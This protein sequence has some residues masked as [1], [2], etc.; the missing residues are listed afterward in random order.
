MT[1]KE[2]VQEFYNLFFINDNKCFIGSKEQARLM[3]QLKFN[4]Y[5]PMKLVNKAFN[6]FISSGLIFKRKNKQK[7]G[8]NIGE[9]IFKIR[10]QN[11]YE[12]IDVNG[13][14]QILKSLYFVFKDINTLIDEVVAEEDIE[15]LRRL[16][17]EKNILIKELK[18]YKDYNTDFSDQG[19]LYGI[20]RTTIKEYIKILDEY[21]ISEVERIKKQK[22]QERIKI[23]DE[24][25]KI[26][27]EIIR[28]CFN[29]LKANLKLEGAL[30]ITVS[31]L[32]GYY[33]SYQD[34]DRCY[35]ADLG[36][37]YAKNIIFNNDIIE[38]NEVSSAFRFKIHKVFTDIQNRLMKMISDG[39]KLTM[40]INEALLDDLIKLNPYC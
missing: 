10:Q 9:V 8:M 16:E 4:K 22:E 29:L 36:V 40:H 30:Q 20:S 3:L 39:I 28:D 15:E 7:I 26:R 38:I 17:H 18:P 33:N 31:S 6:V 23:H 24:K 34:I 13:K 32:E 27:K 2:F 21:D 5:I 11:V 1:N 25:E 35:S 19:L 14:E 37:I 12:R